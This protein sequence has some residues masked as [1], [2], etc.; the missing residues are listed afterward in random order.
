MKKR[1]IS[2]RRFLLGTAAAGA[3]YSLFPSRVLGAN[4]RVNI[5]IIGLGGK[6][7]AHFDDFSKVPNVEIVAISDADKNH[8][9]KGGEKV[10]KHQDLRRLLEMK[11]IDAVVISAPDHWHCLAAILAFQAGKHAYVEK[12]VSHYVWEGRKMVEAARK[13][14][15]IV[16]AGTQQRS[17]P[18]VQECAKDIQSGV[19][20]KVLWA[21]CSKLGIRQ[22]IGKVE[23]PQPVPEGVDYNLWAGPTAMAPIMRKQFHYDWHWQWNWGTGEMGNWGVHYLD[24]LRN[25]LGWDDVPDNVMA[26]GNRWWDDDGQ[27]PNMHMC[28]MEHRGAKIVIDIRNM[29]DP[30]RGG[31]EGAV[32]LG[33][34]EGNY[35][36][37]EGGFI[38]IA[39]GG[40]KAFDKDGKQLKQYKGDGG[41]GHA[42]NFI[43]AVRK[44]SNASLACEVEVGHLSTTLC[45]LANIAFQVGKA[46]PVEELRENLARNEDALNTLDSMLVQLK[47]NNVDLKAKPFIVGPKLRYDTKVEKFTGD[48]AEEANR[49]IKLE[50]RDPFIVPEKV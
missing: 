20:G 38:R 26:A 24:D 28:L 40:G 19:Y 11:D 25:L 8:M 10:A 21:H 4:D 18:A 1:L 49:F 17:C 5:G 32:Y 14:N 50:G 7:H 2:R 9:D 39:R 36:M 31:D 44:G 30:G 29:K 46:A 42:A 16:Q 35:I 33:A 47:G 34:R 15:R 43:D 45:H 27:T 13:Y 3:A 22:P 48:H 23:G 37:C 41:A 12:P 6:G